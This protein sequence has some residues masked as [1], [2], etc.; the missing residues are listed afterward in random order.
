[1]KERIQKVLAN[2]GVGSRR[3]IE[4]MV[5]QGRISVNGKTRVELPILVDPERDKIAVDEEL[6]RLTSRRASERV[7]LLMNKPRGVYSTNVSQLQEMSPKTSTAPRYQVY[8]WP[9]F[10]PVAAVNEVCVFAMLA[11]LTTAWLMVVSST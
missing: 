1:M 8:L 11:M 9:A 4:E 7:Y 10:S 2:A 5:R 3:A 6:V